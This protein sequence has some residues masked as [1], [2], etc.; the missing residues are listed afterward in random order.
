MKWT[1]ET[2]I[3]NLTEVGY[4]VRRY[5]NKVKTHAIGKDNG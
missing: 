2:R 4:N 3:E 5:T 1:M